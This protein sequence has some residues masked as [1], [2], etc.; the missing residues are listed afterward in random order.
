MMRNGPL[1]EER[2]SLTVVEISSSNNAT[3]GVQLEEKNP[4]CVLL[5]E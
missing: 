4:S 3:L 1:A 5:L 2:D